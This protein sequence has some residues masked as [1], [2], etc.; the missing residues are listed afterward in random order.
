MRSI[1]NIVLLLLLIGGPALILGSAAGMPGL[2]VGA[3][4]GIGIC[5]LAGLIPFWFVLIMGGAIVAGFFMWRKNN[6]Q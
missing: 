5:V 4:F 6:G 1:V 3:A 2:I